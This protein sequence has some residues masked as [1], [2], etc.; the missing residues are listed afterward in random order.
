MRGKTYRVRLTGEEEKL[1]DEIVRNETYPE[2]QVKRARILLLLNRGADQSGNP[3]RAPGQS[4]IAERCRCHVDLV[5]TVAKQYAQEGLERVINRK[6]RETPPVPAKVT[7]ELRAKI[8][9]LSSSEPP[10]GHSRWTL[11][12]MEERSKAELGI[13]LSDSAIRTAL[14]K[15][16][17]QN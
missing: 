8:I 13:D 16:P 3:A 14:K 1:L 7:G 11:R 9:A 10:P 17:R 15:M 5:Y 2:R 6:K 12:L 4:E